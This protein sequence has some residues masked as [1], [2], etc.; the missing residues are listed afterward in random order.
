M[1]AQTPATK[2]LRRVQTLGLGRAL[3]DARRVLETR[4]NRARRGN[5]KTVPASAAVSQ[6]V[7]CQPRDICMVV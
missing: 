2:P 3:A 6:E 4:Q 1:D 5:R 7:R